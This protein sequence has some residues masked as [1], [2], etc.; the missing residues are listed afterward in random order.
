MNARRAAATRKT[1][2]PTRDEGRVMGGRY[3]V[4]GRLGSGGMGEV[5]QVIDASTGRSLALK[6]FGGESA[7][8]EVA[9]HQ[10]RFRREFHTMARLVHP[11]IVEVYDYGLDA[12]VPF[13]TME[14]LDGRDLN[15]LAPAPPP[16]ACEL[17]R[18]VASALAFLH[19][20]RLVHRDL[21]PRNVRCTSEG[22][23]KVIDFGVIASP[24]ISGDVAGTAPVISPENVR[25]LPIDHR[26][27]L[28]GLGALAFFL[29]T[30]KH[31]Y[32][33]R[34]IGDLESLWRDGPQRLS[35]LVSDIPPALADLVMSLLCLDPLGRPA[36]AAEV[37]DRLGAIAGLAPVPEVEVTHGYLSSAVMVGRQREVETLR[38]RLSKAQASEGGAILIEGPSGRGKSRLLREMGL[39]AQIAGATVLTAEGTD[40]GRGPYGVLRALARAALAAL[41]EEAARAAEPHADIL[42]RVVP[43]V[44]EGFGRAVSSTF[45]GLEE[46]RIREQ[47][48]L[49]N[50]FVEIAARRTVMIAVDDIQRAD[51]ASAAVLASLAH[52][53]RQ[54]MLVVVA[55]VRTDERLRA[56]LAISAL[57]DASTRVR[58][59]PLSAEEVEAL[60]SGI[61]GEVPHLTRVSSWLQQASGG[62][63]LHCIELARHLVDKGVIRYVEGVWAIPEE[64]RVEG[65]PSELKAAMDARVASLSKKAHAVAEALSVHGG[66]LTLAL[67]LELADAA[68]EQEVFSAVDELLDGEVLLGATDRFRFRHDGLREA[69]LRGLSEERKRALHLRIGNVLASGGDIGPDREAEVGWHLFHGGERSRAGVLLARAGKRLFAASSFSDSVASLEAALEVYEE[70][71]KKP[72]D[73]LELRY[74][75]GMAG[76]FSDRGAVLRHGNDT[77]RAFARYSG[78]E[79]ARR[80]AWLPGI[81][82]LGIALATV[83]LRWLFTRPSRRGPTPI[84]AVNASYVVGAY[85][86]VVHS[87]LIEFDQ[88]RAILKVLEPF[89]AVGRRIPN[90]AWMFVRMSLSMG[91]GRLRLVRKLCDEALDILYA[92]HITPLSPADKK[93]AEGGAFFMRAMATVQGQ[94]P[95]GLEAIAKM[96]SLGLRYFDVSATICKLTY[97]RFRGEEDEAVAIE[98]AFDLQLV[99]AGS[100]WGPES[101]LVYL[102]ALCYGLTR[103]VLGL[104][105]SIVQLTRLV[106]QGFRFEPYL[107]LAKGEY[108]RERGELDASSEALER[109]LAMLD[110]EEAAV[111]PAALGA[112]A[113][114]HLARGEIEQ[115]IERATEAILVAAHPEVGQEAWRLRGVRAL[116]LARAAAGD[117]Q[118][119]ADSLDK[120]ID[121]AMASG[122]PLLCGALHEARAHVALAAKDVGAYTVH[123]QAT[124]SWFRATRNPVLVAR[125]ER[126]LAPSEVATTAAEPVPDGETV[127]SAP[128]PKTVRETV[129]ESVLQRQVVTISDATEASRWAS[130]VLS[131]C[132]GADERA[133]RALEILV[134]ACGATG[135]FLYLMHGG[136]LE[137]V[138]PTQGDEPPEALV[139]EVL[140]T[141]RPSDSSAERVEF[142]W[143]PSEIAG[144][145]H[146]H[147][148]WLFVPALKG[149]LGSGGAVGA[150]LMVGGLDSHSPGQVIVDRVARELFDAGDAAASG[151]A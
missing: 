24:G 2:S 27:D 35:S 52:R 141:E 118:V 148:V 113:E 134:D 82:A 117:I 83:S 23:A 14:L 31:A 132:H 94:A 131:G 129:R 101:Q 64:P 36:T 123:R 104:R 51:E 38:R 111:R 26:A 73:I 151:T 12:S 112:L 85:L 107:D 105:R 146:W 121:E 70:E 50:W 77:F 66:D 136:R 42:G 81:V 147:R 86:A 61:F 100:M 56:S 9:R 32:P 116:A 140:G 22:R 90:A 68:S 40:A 93:N 75:I 76:C 28:Y 10:L 95:S 3:R 25:G 18:D 135:G 79:L 149:V 84:Q 124:A 62:N 11:R 97:R 122:N 98:A 103:D 110:P 47:T 138:A 80:L 88:A 48:A 87:W 143:K 74:M 150:A 54:K 91:L 128:A 59:R 120:G 137:L 39:E 34:K 145:V 30:G 33:A 106:A 6:R 19:T 119:A 130:V 60:L 139:L 41:P 29:L 15:D 7:R 72:A 37:I 63:P 5:Y 1:G 108:H 67:C 78:A 16:R 89:R 65:L 46:E 20:H 114:T 8:T 109:V 55:S 13:F 96:E 92:D 69:L 57:R 102:S 49:T 21:A 45:S 4:Q 43:E 125:A 17:L 99:Q 71:K 115:A 144:E 133:S 142:P 44:R 127:A 53:A 126:L 58:L